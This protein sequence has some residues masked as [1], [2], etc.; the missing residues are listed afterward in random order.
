MFVYNNNS[1]YQ[2]CG[3]LHLDSP[4]Q[5]QQ[6]GGGLAG[7]AQCASTVVR[8]HVEIWE[9]ARPAGGSASAGAA[10]VECVCGV[11][12]PTPAPLKRTSAAENAARWT[13]APRAG[14]WSAASRQWSAAWSAARLAITSWRPLK[15]NETKTNETKQ[16]NFHCRQVL[17]PH[18]LSIS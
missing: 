3:E 16:P 15:R 10:A 14:R 6:P 11:R 17:M 1:P 9:S 5:Q 7:G 12:M 2:R 18:L 13:A 4:P 8:W